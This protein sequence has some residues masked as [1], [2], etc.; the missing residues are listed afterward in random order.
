MASIVTMVFDKSIALS[1]FGTIVISLLFADTFSCPSDILF[2]DDQAGTTHS[3]KSSLPMGLSASHLL[4]PRMSLPSMAT[5]PFNSPVISLTQFLNIS[6]K[7]LAGKIE[8]KRLKVS[9]LGM[10]FK[11]SRRSL[12]K[13]NFSF[14]NSEMSFQD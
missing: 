3:R 2:S 11:P 8:K 9:W 4:G 13:S 7:L 12:K 5:T 6:S 1:N 10:D 14:P